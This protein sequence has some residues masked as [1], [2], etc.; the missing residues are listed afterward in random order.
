MTRIVA[1]G[2]RERV[3]GFALAGVHVAA[4]DD[5]D[6]ARAAWGELPADVGLVI[7]TAA[8]HAALAL[9]RLNQLEERLWVVMPK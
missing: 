7:L 1:I 8:A 2:E 6:A 3:R 9:E 5:A 4:A